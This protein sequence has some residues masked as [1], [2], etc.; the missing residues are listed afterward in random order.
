MKFPE[1]PQPSL[2]N[3]RVPAREDAAMNALPW[4]NC[5]RHAEALRGSVPESQVRT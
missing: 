1:D 2:S 3:N 5:N 4:A